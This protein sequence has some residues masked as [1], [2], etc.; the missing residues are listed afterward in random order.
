MDYSMEDVENT[1]SS[2]SAQTEKTNK[3]TQRVEAGSVTKRYEGTPK[4]ARQFKLS[5]TGS[6]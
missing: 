3:A 2:N 1:S 5:D 4:H 6:I